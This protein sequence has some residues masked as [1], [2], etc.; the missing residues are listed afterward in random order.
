MEKSIQDLMDGL[1]TAQSRTRE[2]RRKEFGA[3]MELRRALSE[4]LKVT[5]MGQLVVSPC[6]A[7]IEIGHWD[8]DSSPIGTCVY[9]SY[10]DPMQDNCLYCDYPE[11]RK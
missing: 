7:A 2:V 11:E 4:R 3:E 5:K 10:Q 6:A 9:D 8:C 1:K